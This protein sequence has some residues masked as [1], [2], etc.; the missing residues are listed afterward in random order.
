MPLKKSGGV[1]EF[2]KTIATSIDFACITRE[3]QDVDTNTKQGCVLPTFERKYS[4]NLANLSLDI[5]TKRFVINKDCTEF[6]PM[7]RDAFT[8]NQKTY[9]SWEVEQIY[10]LICLFIFEIIP[11]FLTF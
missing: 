6:W 7:T 11:I 5:L 9:L 4:L 3:A 1:A 8:A 10:L 2:A